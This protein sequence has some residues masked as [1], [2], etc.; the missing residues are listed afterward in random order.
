MLRE[1]SLCRL[2]VAATQQSIV[3][4]PVCFGAPRQHSSFGELT[5]ALDCFRSPDTGRSAKVFEFCGQ[6]RSGIILTRSTVLD[7]ADGDPG[8]VV[9]WEVMFGLESS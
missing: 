7:P 2:G 9:G 3:C 5:Q 4:R 1:A 6:R 8:H